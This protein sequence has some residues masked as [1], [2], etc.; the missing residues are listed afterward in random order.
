MTIPRALKLT[1]LRVSK[2]FRVIAAP[3]WAF[4][5]RQVPG[6]VLGLLTK[7]ETLGAS[8]WS[9]VANANATKNS[10]RRGQGEVSGGLE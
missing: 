9:P 6:S 8:A 7:S 3:V 1:D 10:R 4:D 5:A 2:S